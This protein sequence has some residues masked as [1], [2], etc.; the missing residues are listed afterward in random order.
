MHWIK[1]GEDDQALAK[2]Q[3]LNIVTVAQKTLNVNFS[4]SQ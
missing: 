3:P 4:D 1:L 2:R